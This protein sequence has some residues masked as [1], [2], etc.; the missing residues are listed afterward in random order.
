MPATEFASVTINGDTPNIFTGGNRPAGSPSGTGFPVSGDPLIAVALATIQAV[1]SATADYSVALPLGA[2]VIAITILEQVVPTGATTSFTAGSTVA[3]V[4]IMTATA[5]TTP[6]TFGLLAVNA[7][8]P[9]LVANFAS[10][11]ASSAGGSIVSIRNT[12]TVPT[13]VGT[14]LLKIEYV[15]A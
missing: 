13:A 2:R 8:R 14:F 3:G 5:V 1:A 9:L 15:M 11:V 7:A 6:Q 4:D 12:Q 10:I